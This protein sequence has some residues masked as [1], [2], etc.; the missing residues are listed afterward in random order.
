[1]KTRLLILPAFFA[2]LFLNSCTE[3]DPVPPVATA[4]P[5]EQAI[6]SGAPTSISLTSSVTGTTFTWTVELSG[7][8]GGTAGSGSSIAQTLTATG[9]AAGTAT[10]TITP[11]ANGTAG[12]PIKVKITVNPPKVTF[13][14]DIKPLL[15]AS[16]TPCHMPGGANPNKFDD[17]TTVKNKISVILD[18]VQ[19]EPT[20]AGFMPRGGTK[21]SAANIALLNKWVADGVL[22]K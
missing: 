14:A 17:Y 6:T 9:G 13:V 2:I 18:R 8:S 1:M 20:A 10:Y 19:R 16:C 21:L 11:T 15:T 12:T 3:E 5:A 22:E 4:T 7:V